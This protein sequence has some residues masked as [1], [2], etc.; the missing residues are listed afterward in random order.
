M[1][2]FA[3]ADTGIGDEPHRNR[4]QGNLKPVGQV[5]G[6][7]PRQAATAPDLGLPLDQGDGRNQPGRVNIRLGAVRRN[8]GVLPSPFPP[9]GCWAD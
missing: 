2:P 1:W 9:Q 6:P 5:G 4:A 3:F 7:G 8:P